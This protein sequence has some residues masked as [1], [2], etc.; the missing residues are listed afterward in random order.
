M[1]WFLPAA[2]WGDTTLSPCS[3]KKRLTS[4]KQIFDSKC[5]LLIQVET[6][7]VES[8]EVIAGIEIPMTDDV[9]FH[10]FWLNPEQKRESE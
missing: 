10:S 5:Y 7:C 3:G 6:D 4:E 8:L 1:S 9:E 2:A